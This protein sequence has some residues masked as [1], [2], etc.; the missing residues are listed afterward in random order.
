MKTHKIEVNE[1][2]KL[3]AMFNLTIVRD[4][5]K[6]CPKDETVILLSHYSINKPKYSDNDYESE[7]WDF[8]E[9]SDYLNCSLIVS[10]YDDLCADPHGIYSY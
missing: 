9:L 2:N 10:D 8:D 4:L 5:I 6:N 1:V 3:A 7:F